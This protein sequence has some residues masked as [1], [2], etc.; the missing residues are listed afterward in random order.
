MC[1]REC[2]R[3]CLLAGTVGRLLEFRCVYV[4]ACMFVYIG[5]C[6]GVCAGVCVCTYLRAPCADSCNYSVCVCMRICAYVSMC[7]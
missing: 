1:I 6:V 5:V 2:V 4:C 7:V 3:M